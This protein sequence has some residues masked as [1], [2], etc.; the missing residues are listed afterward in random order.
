[1]KALERASAEVDTAPP[2]AEEFA[3]CPSCSA[4]LVT[5]EY[6]CPRCGYGRKN[7]FARHAKSIRIGAICLVIGVI[8]LGLGFF[9]GAF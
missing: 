5:S 2:A 7:F 9:A 6:G 8:L 1:V 3:V 4:V